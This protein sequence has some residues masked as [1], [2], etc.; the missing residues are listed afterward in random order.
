[1]LPTRAKV[2]EIYGEQIEAIAKNAH[3]QAQGATYVVYVILDHSRP[4][5]NGFFAGTPIY[6]GQ[7]GRIHDRIVD[8]CQAALVY[9]GCEGSIKAT[10][11]KMI[12]SGN[13][14]SVKVVQLCNGKDSSLIAETRW[15]QKLLAMG[16][17]LKNRTPLQARVM[18]QKQWVDFE[19]RAAAVDA[20]QGI[21]WPPAVVVAATGTIDQIG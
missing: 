11:A 14:P 21:A 9:G 10:L 4:D 8:H 2:R 1:M 18:T 15:A 5:P 17:Q 20:A 12:E 6:V 7:S 3:N 13:L 19:R 16:Y